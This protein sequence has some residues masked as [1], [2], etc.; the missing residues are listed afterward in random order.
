MI[1][2][3]SGTNA[4]TREELISMIMSI[5]KSKASKYEIYRLFDEFDRDSKTV[6]NY[7]QFFDMIAPYNKEYRRNLRRK[8]G[9]R[10]N[11]TIIGD[12]AQDIG[13]THKERNYTVY[14]GFNK[15]RR[16][17][18]RKT[19][20]S[21]RGG[22]RGR[23]PRT[24]A[25][26]GKGTWGVDNK[27]SRKFMRGGKGVEDFK[28]YTIETKKCIRKLFKLLILTSKNFDYS[29]AI[30][31]DQLFNLFC[32][33]DKNVKGEI[34]LRDL[35]DL[36]AENGVVTKYRELKAIIKKFDINFDG[37][38]SFDELY[39]EMSPKRSNLPSRRKKR[40]F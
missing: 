17:R 20:N 33:M 22:S 12:K 2:N 31:Q 40:V 10:D 29:K 34:S 27:S 26:S 19:I 38:I 11:E 6:L 28:E 16:S 4:I 9:I 30:I 1:T 5:A 7:Q 36:L 37:K 15:D 24:S 35:G 14:K 25:L 23:S 32:L 39:E 13:R 8:E 18:S 3:V 21:S